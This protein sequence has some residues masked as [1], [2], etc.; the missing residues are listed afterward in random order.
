MLKKTLTV[1]D[2]RICGSQWQC[3]TRDS[4]KFNAFYSISVQKFIVLFLFDKHMVTGVDYEH[5]E[6]SSLIP[7]W[8][9]GS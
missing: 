7:L 1:C 3:P 2:V 5:V 8:K 9:R 6:N 4:S